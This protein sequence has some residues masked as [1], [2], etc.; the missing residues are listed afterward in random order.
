M[1]RSDHGDIEG[2]EYKRFEVGLARLHELNIEGPGGEG[3]RPLAMLCYEMASGV[4]HVEGVQ[5]ATHHLNA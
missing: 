2:V 5:R 4:D 3:E 1:V